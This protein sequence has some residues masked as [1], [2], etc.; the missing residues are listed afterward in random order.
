MT[1]LKI[2]IGQTWSGFEFL[3]IKKYKRKQGYRVDFIRKTWSGKFITLATEKALDAD[4]IIEKISK[5]LLPIFEI[6][7][8]IKEQI[9]D[10]CKS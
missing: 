2:P 5:N 3:K 6:P 8:E 7:D 9:K 10:F 4:E 1:E